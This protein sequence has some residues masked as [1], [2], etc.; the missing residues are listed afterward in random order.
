MEK[1]SRF[2]ALFDRLKKVKNIEYFIFILAIAIIISLAGNL[3]QPQSKGKGEEKKVRSDE[4]LSESSQEASKEKGSTDREKRLK[5]VLS[6]IQGAGQV[7]VMIT[8]KT[9]K[10][11]VPAMNTVESS[12]ETEEKDSNGG[13]RRTTQTDVNTQ[14]VSMD[15]PDGSQPLISRENEPEVQGVIVVAEGAED[16]QVR[17]GLQQAVQTLLGIQSDQVEVFVMDDNRMEE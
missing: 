2:H 1:E 12:T 14:P 4:A 17:I 10:E 3:L 11:V 7:D 9:G 15:S 8:Y 6:V 13:V 16:I 5:D